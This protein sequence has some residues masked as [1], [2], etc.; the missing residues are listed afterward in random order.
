M[1]RPLLVAVA[2]VAWLVACGGPSALAQQHSGSTSSLKS[3]EPVLFK[4]DQVEYDRNLGVIVARG[5]VEFTQGDYILRADTVSY[6]QRADL[7]T[8]SGNVSLLQPSG[9]VIFADHVELTGDLKDGIAS[10]LRM[11][12]IDNARFAAVGGRMSGGDVTVLRKAVYS[13][14]EPCKQHPERAPTWQIK[15]AKVTHNKTDHTIEYEDAV[16]EMYGVPIAYLPYMSQ[17]D[18]TVKRKSG[19]LAPRYGHDSNLGV[20]LETPYYFAIAPDRDAT[21]SPIFTQNDGVV[22]AGDYRERFADGDIKLQ[23]SATRSRADSTD[24]KNRGHLF[25]NLRYDLNDTWRAGAQMQLASDD[26]YLQRY[27][28]FSGDQLTNHV[29]VEGFRGEDYASAQAYYWRGLRN[30]DVPGQTPIVA[31]KLDYNFVS[32]P[33]VAGGRWTMNADLMALTRTAGTDSRRASLV[34]G[35][36]LPHVARDGEVYRLYATLQTEAYWVNGVQEPNNPTGELSSGV[37]GRVFPR[38]GLDWRYPFARVGRSTTQVI[39]P[40]VAVVV[41]PNGGNP[42]LIPNEDSQE[43]ELD[44]TNLMSPNRF[45]G[46]DRVEGGQRVAYGL[47]G[48]LYGP[49]SAFASAFV[50]QSYALRKNNLFPAGSGL[51]DKLSDYVGRVQIR[52]GSLLNVVYRFRLDKD[53]FQARRNELQFNTGP[54]A[55][56]LNIGY[57]FLD[58]QAGGEFPTRE[59]LT[60]NLRSQLTREWAAGISTRRDLTSN[61]GTLSEGASVTYTNDCLIARLDVERSFIRDRDVKP[62]TTVLLR[63]VFR[64]LGQVQ[65]GLGA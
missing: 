28:F 32:E 45:S 8:A 51:E 20:L 38:L 35:W 30:I 14:C 42:P 31:P 37:T 21:F 26:T 61:G 22:L 57:L 15:A 19:F 64:T 1:P 58:Q 65:S 4:A 2:I 10:N 7:V 53:N 55:L 6:N 50:G 47:K 46:L 48:G 12:T 24:V 39:E 63:L 54:K 29:F 34:T 59:E 27:R 9:D 60:L 25:G 49:G 18:P 56:N 41:A 3:T 5:H 33:G 62:S 17:P 13:A 11:R 40:V 16:M 52:P 43:F 23:A 44:D 36:S